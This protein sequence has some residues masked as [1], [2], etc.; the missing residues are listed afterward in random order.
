MTSYP[1]TRAS[2]IIQVKDASNQKAWE[3]FVDLYRPVIYRAAVEKG[4]Q[5]A[6]AHDLAQQVLISVAG[7]VGRWEKSGTTVRFRHWLR[8]ITRNAII[9]VLSRGP[10]EQAN[11]SIAVDELLSETPERDPTTE[12]IVLLERRRELFLRA[13]EIVRRD[14]TP[15]TWAAFKLTTIDGASSAE[16]AK[17]LGKS[18]GTIY[19]SRSRILQRLRDAV[20]ELE[21]Y[22]P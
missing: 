16:A 3:E 13:A 2:L 22:H 5:D 8:R 4:F 9:N 19:A 15:E 7:A 14:V 12:E 21:E 6:D 18:I 1:E 10:R 20:T 17:Q 11:G